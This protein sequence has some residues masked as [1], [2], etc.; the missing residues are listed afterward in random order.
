M[1][2]EALENSLVTLYASG[3]S[4]RRLSIEL[5]VSRER[6]SRILH[7]N[8]SQRNPSDEDGGEKP[9]RRSMLDPYKETIAE[10]L[11]K[12]TDPPPTKQ[13]V[14]EMIREK[15]YTGG[16]SILQGYLTGVMG[17]QLPDPIRCI[18][19][20]PGERGYH[21]WSD[22]MIDF[23]EGGRKKVTFFSFILG[24]SRR[25]YVEVVEDKTQRTLFKSLVNTFVYFDGVPREIK[26]DNQKACVDRW[27]LG[28]P[29]FNKQL[30][31]FATFYR[32]RP[33]AI[34][35]G[36]PK[37]N[38][39]IERPFYYLEV[40]FLNARKFFNLAD[41]K[42]ALRTWLTGTND[43]RIHRRTRQSPLERFEEEHGFL[44]ALPREQYDTSRLEYR[45]VNN[46]SCVE[47][48]GYYYVVPTQYMFESCVVR[49]SD[50]EIVIYA[51]S[52]EEIQRYSLAEKG[53]QD[54]Y[55]G[56]SWQGERP[57]VSLSSSEIVSRLE[58]FG[59]EMKQYVEL[60]KRHKTSS[61]THHLRQILA[62]KVNYH[63]DDIMIAVR[64][65]MQ[66][67]IYESASIGNFLELNATKKNELRLLP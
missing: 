50:T 57:K 54:R 60:I 5:K 66:H 1:K 28:G 36:K 21:D 12:Y 3:W 44:Q 14:L 39:K 13:R 23:T 45:V 51:P 7:Q 48:C 19:T 65:A 20:A 64:R 40:N 49:V 26:S 59:P 17:K 52:C 27:E 18:E 9:L 55:I 32:F 24:Y 6:V 30:L 46:E 25:Q 2:D 43:Q 58:T 22:Y 61:Y 11:E 16:R 29:V 41:L 10:I 15:G 8:E 42:E 47:W 33:L 35:P 38:L 4:V 53:R 63:V 56:R 34:H 62:L 37:E 67:R 31:E